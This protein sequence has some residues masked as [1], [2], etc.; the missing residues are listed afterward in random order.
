MSGFASVLM[1]GARVHPEARIH[2]AD[3]DRG[4]PT[5]LFVIALGEGKHMCGNFDTKGLEPDPM[6]ACGLYAW[7]D[8]EDAR[9]VAAAYEGQFEGAKV[10]AKTLEQCRQMVEEKG[11]VMSDIKAVLFMSMMRIRDI[12]WVRG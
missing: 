9:A 4:L 10:E 3:N 6:T 8:I 11:K 1:P 5:E 2:A 12:L 7:P